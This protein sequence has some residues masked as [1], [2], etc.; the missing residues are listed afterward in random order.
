VSPRSRFIAARLAYVVIVL[1]ATLANLHASA[2]LTAVHGRLIRAL[3]PSLTW[4]DAVDGLRNVVLFAG[5]GAV[6]VVTSL[7]GRAT[8]EI[9][10]ATLISFLLGATAE[11]LQLLSPVRTSSIIDVATN[12]L[13][14]FAGAVA[15][16]GLL[17]TIQHARRDKS[18]LGIPML[19]V[20]APYALAAECE[21]L[22]PLFHSAPLPMMQGG[23][24][25]RLT[26]ALGAAM[27]L[28]WSE[29]PLVDVPLFGAA[30]F[31]LVALLR[32]RGQSFREAVP[33]VVF[34]AG[35]VMVVSHVM[36]GAF[37]LAVRWEAIATDAA[38]I[39][40][41]AWAAWRWL[42]PITREHRGA[43]RVRLMMIAYAV[44][45]VLWG[46][47]PFAIETSGRVIADQIT[48]LALTPLESL[49]ERVDV[50]SALHVMQQF[51]LYLPVGALLAVWPLRRVGRLANLRPGVWLAAVIELGHIV[52]AGRTFDVTN[53]L[54]AVAGLAVGWVAVRRCGFATYGELVP[55]GR[56][57]AAP[58]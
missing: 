44:L 15:T 29:I 7:S 26:I 40:L 19:L 31:L 25:T 54:L 55:A 27:P 36:H 4:R 47:R 45:L 53:F 5:L 10:P 56:R 16:V 39:A 23:P 50:F 30:G 42:G 32:E 20:A 8:R 6:W 51:L 22:A 17:A 37:S 2:D 35:A 12:T 49:A 52:V 34:G 13:G 21:A 41:G 9:R 33:T 43:A 18:Y 38:S 11:G 46:W 24:L 28:D 3:T 48:P 58:G 1:L 14:G 57:H